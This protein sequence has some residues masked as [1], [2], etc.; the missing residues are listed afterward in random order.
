MRKILDRFL[1][2]CKNDNLYFM[3][4]DMWRFELFNEKNTNRC[5]NVGVQEPNMINI[6][7]GLASQGKKVIIYGVA[8]FNIYK[9]YE[10]LKFYRK[11]F[12]NNLIFVNAGSNGCYDHLGVGHTLDDDK[13]IMDLLDIPLFEPKT[14]KEFLSTL[15]KC[16]RN[17]G[18]YYIRLG[19]DDCK[20]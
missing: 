11:T 5:I 10:Q 16:I 19:C 12:G 20:W 14:G 9:G 7:L 1:S 17:N 2:K 18:S 3:H 13:E 15:C 6:A 8:G 4:A